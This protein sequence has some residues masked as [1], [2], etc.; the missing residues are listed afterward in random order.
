MKV[1]PT[2]MSVDDW[3]NEAKSIFNL[4]V[5]LLKDYGY[6]ENDLLFGHSHIVWEDYNF[7]S[8]H[9]E[10]CIS[11]IEKSQRCWKSDICTFLV[12][13]SLVHLLQLPKYEDCIDYEDLL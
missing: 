5:K 4:H 13:S 3:E 7:E 11:E 2:T 10:W 8:D 6:S 9:I 12:R 1:L